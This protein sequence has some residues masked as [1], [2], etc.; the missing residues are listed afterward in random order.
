MN[1]VLVEKRVNLTGDVACYM[2]WLA[3]IRTEDR[4]VAV[5]VVRRKFIPPEGE[6]YQ[7]VVFH[8][9]GAMNVIPKRSQLLEWTQK[10]ADSVSPIRPVRFY[11]DTLATVSATLALLGIEFASGEIARTIV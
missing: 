2:G 11:D 9:L 8:Y 7:D 3:H 10:I 4:D 1:S 6:Y 5:L